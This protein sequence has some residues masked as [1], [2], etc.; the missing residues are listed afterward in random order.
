LAYTPLAPLPHARQ[1]HRIHI[2]RR[3]RRP[4]DPAVTRGDMDHRAIDESGHRRLQYVTSKRGG[5]RKLIRF[6]PLFGWLCG[7]RSAL[8]RNDADRLAAALLAELH[9]A[10]GKRE[11]RVVS[12]AADVDT[13]VELGPALPDKDLAGVHDLAAEAL[14]PKTLGVGVTTVAGAG[15]ALLVCHGW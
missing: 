6:P 10:G 15:C 7:E 2:L 3:H 9:G 12:T 5:L 11:Q 1:T 4:A 8:R 14:D 13:G